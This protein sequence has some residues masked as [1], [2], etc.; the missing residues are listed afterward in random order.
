MRKSVIVLL[1]VFALVGATAAAALRPAPLAPLPKVVVYKNASCGCCSK[2]IDYLK[3]AGFPVEVH[4]VDDVSEFADA[5]GVPSALRSC[6]TA[7]VQGYVIEGH[8]PADLMQK[9]LT[10]K[11]RLAGLSVP[12]MVVGSPGMDGS[13]AQHYDVVSWSKDGKTAV[14]AKR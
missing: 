7:V 4:D 1:S 5:S 9:L 12:G 2:W 3:S 6:H 8:V 11:P 13:P 10:E 14:Y